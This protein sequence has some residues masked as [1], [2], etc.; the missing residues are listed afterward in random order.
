[1][2]RVA[3][4]TTM[5][6]NAPS[7]HL[8]FS[9]VL[10]MLQRMGMV[11]VRFALQRRLLGKRHRLVAGERTDIF[12]VAR[13]REPEL[14]DA[15][16]GEAKRQG[17][18]VV[19]ET[20]DHLLFDRRR[21]APDGNAGRMEGYLGR[22]DGLLVSTPYLAA[23]LGR[24]NP[25]TFVVPNLLAPEIWDVTH[26]FISR[27]DRPLRIC[28]IGTALME[29]N[30]SLVLPAM[31]ECAQRYGRDVLFDLQ[32]NAGYLPDTV[33]SLKNVR[34][35]GKR[36]PYRKFAKDLQNSSCAVGIVPLSDLRFNRAKSAIKYLEYGIS[37]IPAVFSGVEAYAGL[38]DG[39]TCVLVVNDPDRWTEE[40][41]RLVEGP[42][43]RAAL[44]AS[45]H[46]DVKSRHV[47]DEDK[48][49]RYGELLERIH[50]GTGS[51]A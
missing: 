37:G 32:G 4:V 1:M 22:A 25:R 34:I 7:Y 43:I 48:A 47:L 36:V 33:R 10:G 35:A 24:F 39:E 15:V 31:R 45:A 5:E 46:A 50:D 6:E 49:L 16:F 20:D 30:I 11:G 21:D 9:S 38:P 3:V 42:A 17:A 14:L 28:A 51:G 40:I 44:A 8:R 2:M 12:L 18:A 26:A 13:V 23:E 41:V 27:D 19:Y 29:E